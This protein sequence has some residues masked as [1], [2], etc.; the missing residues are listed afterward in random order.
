MNKVDLHKLAVQS[1]GHFKLS[2]LMQKRMRQLNEGGYRPSS[3]GK[4]LRTV[5]AEVDEGS[6]TLAPTAAEA[7]ARTLFKDG[8]ESHDAPEKDD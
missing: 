4:L 8:G 5:L 2:S 3:A 7:A 6:V 1:G